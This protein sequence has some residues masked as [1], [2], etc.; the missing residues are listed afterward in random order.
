MNSVISKLEE[1]HSKSAA[2]AHAYALRAKA[3]LDQERWNEATNDAQNV[4]LGK[5]R[6]VAS[7]ASLSLSYRVW[8]DAEEKLGQNA[9]GNKERVIAVLQHWQKAQPSYRSKLQREMQELLEEA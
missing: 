5:L 7:D 4:V 9:D 3:R 6:Q 1:S 8:A 2:L